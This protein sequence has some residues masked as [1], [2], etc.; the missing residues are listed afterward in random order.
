MSG[1]AKVISVQAIRDVR[2]ALCAFE[3]D[4]RGALTS[5]EMEVRRAV[6]WVRQ[7]QVAYWTHEIRRSREIMSQARSDLN[8]KRISNHSPGDV[9][10]GEEKEEVREAKRRLRTAEEKLEIVR[11]WGP[12]LES[13]VNEYHSYAR[14]LGDTLAG[15]LQNAL[16]RLDRL[17][18]SLEAYMALTAPSAPDLAPAPNRSAPTSAASSTDSAPSSGPVPPATGDPLPEDVPVSEPAP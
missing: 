10:L 14:P 17:V 1:R 13:A 8:R 6:Q 15:D 11:R 5:I 7:E 9:S 18:A 3:E 12:V 2:A 16:V 4:A